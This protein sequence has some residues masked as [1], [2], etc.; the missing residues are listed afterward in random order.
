MFCVFVKLGFV[1]MYVST[2]VKDEIVDVENVG[3]IDAGNCYDVNLNLTIN[4]SN[5]G[6]IHLQCDNDL[7]KNDELHLAT[8]EA[9]I[10]KWK[11]TQ[12]CYFMSLQA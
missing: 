5:V 4:I 8:I 11:H 6:I 7:L 12:E 1:V 2:M 9:Q 3:G 10:Q